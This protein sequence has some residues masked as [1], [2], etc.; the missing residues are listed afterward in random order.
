M[1]IWS[2]GKVR[3]VTPEE[4]AQSQTQERLDAIAERHRSLTTEEVS[5]MIITQ[6]INTLTVDD[7]TALRMKDFYP[8]W[9]S[10]ATYEPG[11]KAC[12]DGKLWRVRQSHTSQ[13]G[14]EPEKNLSLWE[15]VNETYGGTIDD[16]VPYEG[17]MT[18]IAGKY[19]YQDNVI[20]L[21]DRDTDIPV[22]QPL[23]ELMGLYV[24]EV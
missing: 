18:L 20:Y 13:A 21:C 8:E 19:Y 12:H 9:V 2:D 14:W 7:R 1:R 4:I 11:F 22:Y 6:Q 10:G 15:Q 17:N 23:R 24:K 16:P 3:D 5:K